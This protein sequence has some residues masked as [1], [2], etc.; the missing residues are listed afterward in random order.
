MKGTLAVR[1]NLLLSGQNC[2]IPDISRARDESWVRGNRQCIYEE[3][4]K[5]AEWSRDFSA[6]DFRLHAL[7]Q[8]NGE[9][10]TRQLSSR[11]RTGRNRGEYKRNNITMANRAAAVPNYGKGSHRRMTLAH[12]QAG[13]WAA[14]RDWT[15][16]WK[17]I[18]AV[19]Y[20][21]E[22]QDTQQS[23]VNTHSRALEGNR[24][25]PHGQHAETCRV[26]SSDTRRKSVLVSNL[27]HSQLCQDGCKAELRV[28]DFSNGLY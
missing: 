27:I 16:Q 23:S 15:E 8:C 2:L 11:M 20:S 19:W 22:E 24:G 21:R 25:E 7:I 3:E 18:Q 10:A 26:T 6:K 5:Y 4:G 17:D 9:G 12:M 13:D 28:V 14:R 1:P